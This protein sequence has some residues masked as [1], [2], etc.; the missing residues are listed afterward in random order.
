MRKATTKASA[1]MPAP[2]NAANNCSRKSPRKREAVTAALTNAVDRMRPPRGLSEPE[3]P[4]TSPRGALPLASVGVLEA[5]LLEVGVVMAGWRVDFWR[6]FLAERT[7]VATLGPLQVD[8][9]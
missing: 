7:S 4:G 3:A 8:Q 1:H 5:W 9:L 2:S 6:A